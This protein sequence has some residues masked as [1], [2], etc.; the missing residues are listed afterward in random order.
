MGE[1]STM[2]DTDRIVSD[3]RHSLRSL[4]IFSRAGGIKLREYQVAAGN[5]IV[6]SVQQA[7]GMT[8]VVIFPRQSGKDELLAHLKAY[9]MSCCAWADTG[10]VEVNPTYKPQTINAIMRLDNRMTMNYITQPL[11]GKRSDFMRTVGLC[12]TSF[13]SGDGQANV[14]GA[15]ASLLMIVNEAQDILPVIYDKKFEPMRASTNAT[16]VFCGT[17]WTSNTLLARETRSARLL[18]EK[19]GLQ[20][21]FFYT[22]D[23]VGKINKSYA[24]FVTSV[25]SKHGRQHPLIKTQYFCEE[26]DAQAGMFNPARRLLMTGDQPAHDH[27][28]PGVPCAFLLDVAGQDEARMA[29]DDDAPLQNPGRDSVSLT[30]VDMD[31]S[32][33]PILQAPTYRAAHRLQ[34]TGQ[35]HLTVFGQFKALAEAWN[36]LYIVIDA[37]G[38]GE[39]LWAL[40]D[41]TFPGRVIPV[42]FTAPEKSDIGYRFLAIIE[43]GRF[44]DLCPADPVRAQYDACTSEILPGPTKTLRW[45]VPEGTRAE[46]TGEL[47]HD[48]YLLAD[49]L[50]AVLD[51]MDWSIQTDAE[52]GEGFDPL[53]SGCNFGNQAV[54]DFR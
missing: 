52:A 27:P 45:G 42:K 25:V 33:I 46:G 40:L 21:V 28:L 23:D 43:T 17:V 32:T 53:E 19:D 36:P 26:I 8:F 7:Q 30:I 12:R 18:E 3:Y 20:R 35:N 10:I 14:V 41:K 29:L 49:A 50:V 1:G 11:W 15:T 24:H 44:R 54:G 34:W 6:N 51:R 9:L 5:A 39:G 38:V 31:L 47:I 13:L 16:V 48:D 37:T 4:D 22:A 2:T